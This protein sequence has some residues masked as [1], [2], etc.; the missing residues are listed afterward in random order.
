M[1]FLK[2]LRKIPGWVSG[3]I[4][5]I[6]AVIG[7]V[8]LIKTNI[9]LGVTAL[10]VVVWML[11]MLGLVYVRLAKKEGRVHLSDGRKRLFPK[12]KDFYLLVYTGWLVL[13][14]LLL[15]PLRVKPV[16]LFMRYGFMSDPPLTPSQLARCYDVD[17]ATLIVVASFVE[18]GSDSYGITDL[19]L[20]ELRNGMTDIEGI[21]I[22]PLEKVIHEQQGSNYAQN[23]LDDCE[24]TIVLWGWYKVTESNALVMINIESLETQGP[25]FFFSSALSKPSNQYLGSSDQIADF[26]LQIDV[27]H[28]VS[29]FVISLQGVV[30]MNQGKFSEAVE[31][32]DKVIGNHTWRSQIVNQS[33]LYE[34]RGLA[35]VIIGRMNQIQDDSELMKAIDD[36]TIAIELGSD[37]RSLYTNRGIA[38]AYLG[39]YEEAIEDIDKAIQ[40]ASNDFEL[41]QGHSDKGMIYFW[42]GSNTEAINSLNLA[43]NI[44]PENYLAYL[45]RGMVYQ[46]L[47]NEDAAKS[48]FSIAEKFIPTMVV[49][50][51]ILEK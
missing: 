19:L 50:S 40:V 16:Q 29:A 12:Y 49:R 9:Y 3:L 8:V 38:L 48:D 51:S 23:V 35:H 17:D 18:S 2:Y 47:G 39:R 24:A 1:D 45:L 36:F 42:S 6:A 31:M 30:L 46:E 11:A 44:N 33:K 14:L 5:L 34:L 43:I 4:S 25:L 27:S 15:I 28:D 26:T 41:S 10:G 13:F 21:G 7:F 20:S 32:F 37:N 22:L